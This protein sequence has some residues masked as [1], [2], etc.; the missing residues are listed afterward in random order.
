M[1]L[2]ECELMAAVGEEEESAKKDAVEDEFD[3]K[4]RV[5]HKYFLQEWTLLNS[6]LRR[7]LSDARVSDP[8]SVHKIRS[9]VLSPPFLTFLIFQSILCYD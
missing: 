5:L 3:S 7:I 4:E 6:I 8:S 2:R 1:N 9:I